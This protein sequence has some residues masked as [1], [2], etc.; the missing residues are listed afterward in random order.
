MTTEA[1]TNVKLN[2]DDYRAIPEDGLRHELLDGEH[3]VSPAPG[4]T[5]QRTLAALF[6]LL[7]LATTAVFLLGTQRIVQSGWQ[8][9]A[10]VCGTPWTRSTAAGV[11]MRGSNPPRTAAAS[12]TTTPSGAVRSNDPGAGRRNE[13]A[14]GRAAQSS[15]A[16]PSRT[17]SARPSRSAT[18][19]ATCT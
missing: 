8:A 14:A 3:V 5:H 15:A 12:M 7:A 9:W 19:S 6:V 16:R 13:H 4:A 10:R 2:L 17:C 11:R 1:A 18:V